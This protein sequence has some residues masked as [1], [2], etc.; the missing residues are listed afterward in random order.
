[1]PNGISVIRRCCSSSMRLPVQPQFLAANIFFEPVLVTKPHDKMRCF[2]A[3]VK[4][5][6]KGR[7]F[8]LR[9]NFVGTFRLPTKNGE[10]IRV[11]ADQKGTFSSVHHRQR[12]NVSEI[13]SAR[14][15]WRRVRLYRRWGQKTLN[16]QSL[17]KAAAWLFVGP[18]SS[19]GWDGWLHRKGFRAAFS[20]S[21]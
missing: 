14:Q 8:D 11:C 20:A 19:G 15:I 1:M 4:M 9:I 7:P 17:Q 21:T 13:I 3:V 2:V 12:C 10:R 5:L 18:E 6:A 16:G